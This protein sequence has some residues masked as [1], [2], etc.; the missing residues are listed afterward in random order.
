MRRTCG[1]RVFVTAGALYAPL[2]GLEA[3]GYLYFWFADPTPRCGGPYNRC[4][5]LLPAGEQ[6]LTVYKAMLDRVWLGVSLKG[7]ENA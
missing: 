6:A 7:V 3:K 4:F 2:D 5:K 1:R